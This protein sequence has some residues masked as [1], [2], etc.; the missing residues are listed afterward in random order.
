MIKTQEKTSRELVAE[1]R[2]KHQEIFNQMGTPNVYFYPKMAY[3][4]QDKDELYISLFPSELSKGDDI[5]TEFVNR[6]YIPEDSN[7]TLWVLKYNPFW[8]E[9]YE[10]TQSMNSSTVRYLVPVSE[11]TKVNVTTKVMDA[12]PFKSLVDYALDD[13]PLSEMTIRDFATVLL[14]KPLS[15]KQWLN[16]LIVENE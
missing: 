10:E 15:N 16:K 6:D 11:L 5:Y 13:C 4:P 8:K 2:E 14:K 9:E 1:L 12:D 7:R 3:R